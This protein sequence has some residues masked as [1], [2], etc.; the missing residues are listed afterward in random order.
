MT[1]NL[2][3]ENKKLKQELHDT[4]DELRRQR[5]KHSAGVRVLVFDDVPS[6]VLNGLARVASLRSEVV[7]YALNRFAGLA[8]AISLL[9]LHG[10]ELL[11]KC[12][13]LIGAADFSRHKAL[14]H[15]VLHAVYKLRLCI[16]TIAKA[17]VYVVNLAFDVGKVAC[18]DVSIHNASTIAVVAAP[19][20]AALAKQEQDDNPNPVLPPHAHAAIV[21]IGGL[22]R[23]CHNSA[24]RR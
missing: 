13:L 5:D 14:L 20:V 22:Y 4:R 2:Y 11:H 3:E 18:K 16:E 10:V 15:S 7:V 23:H 1:E 21:I 9:H 24:V 19:T 8:A 6:A 12:G 17:V